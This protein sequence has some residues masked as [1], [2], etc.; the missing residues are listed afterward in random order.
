MDK[1]ELELIQAGA[2]GELDQAGRAKLD[3]LLAGSAQAREQHDS[4]LRLNALLGQVPPVEP[5]ETLHRRILADITLPRPAGRKWAQF[6]GF[7]P[8]VLRYGLAAGVAVILTMAVY[9]GGSQLNGV[10]Y[11]KLVGTISARGAEL[12]RV[13]FLQSGAQGSVR[14]LE[15]GDTYALEF[16]LQADGPVSFDVNFADS[17]LRFDAFAQADLNLEAMSLT[18]STLSARTGGSQRFVVLMRHD[19]ATDPANARIDLVLSRGGEV[20]GQ[21]V[22]RIH[23][24]R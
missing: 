23:P 21:G 12:D 8:G 10:S 5:P 15:R 16:D 3:A 20:I 24:G 17:G 18:K 1:D 13:E 22:L 9:Q 19:A 11:D 6:T 4:L 2:D 7:L 14:L